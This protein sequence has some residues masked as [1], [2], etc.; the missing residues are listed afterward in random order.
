MERLLRSLK[1]ILRII[2]DTA[3]L[4]EYFRY[5]RCGSRMDS[6]PNF[7]LLNRVFHSVIS[8]IICLKM[9]KTVQILTRFI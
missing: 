6:T 2:V 7:L 9:N 5:S 1:E 8:S 4:V 3:V